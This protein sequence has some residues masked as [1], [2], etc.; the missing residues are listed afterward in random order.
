MSIRPLPF[1]FELFMEARGKFYN[2]YELQRL[3][4]LAA[5]GS[6]VSIICGLFFSWLSF[7]ATYHHNIFTIDSINNIVAYA[8][9]FIFVFV[10]FFISSM[11]ARY[12]RK[13]FSVY[14]P[15]WF[16]VS[17]F[18]SLLFSFCFFTKLW[19]FSLLNTAN[20]PLNA[21]PS[22]LSLTSSI[23]ALSIVLAALTGI[24][25]FIASILYEKYQDK[26]KLLILIK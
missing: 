7:Q 12:F 17:F 24:L 13:A 4:F 10:S 3:L 21:S 6:V 2:T 22:F 18:G 19:I 16:F 5:V 8:E 1:R 9:F 25:S 14:A 23:V 11:M 15:S 20:D 26:N